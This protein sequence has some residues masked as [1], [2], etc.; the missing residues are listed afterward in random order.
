MPQMD[1]SE[2][3]E[4]VYAGEFVSPKQENTSFTMGG[5]QG[6]GMFGASGGIQT[7][8]QKERLSKYENRFRFLIEDG[9]VKDWYAERLVD[10]RIVWS[11]Q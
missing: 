8:E 9:E 7:T 5:A 1:G 3:W 4:Y 6:S 2:I 11:D 10:G